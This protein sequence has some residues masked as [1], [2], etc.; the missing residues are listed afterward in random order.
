MQVGNDSTK[1]YFSEITILE[2]PPTIWEVFII[3]YYARKGAFTPNS[4]MEILTVFSIL[5]YFS[6]PKLEISTIFSIMNSL[7]LPK[8]EISTVF[9]ILNML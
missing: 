3:T 2:S 1:S 4:K 6:Y 7:F 9:S 8:L 5:N